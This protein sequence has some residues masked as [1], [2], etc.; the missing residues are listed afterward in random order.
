MQRSHHA[1]DRVV[2]QLQQ[3]EHSVSRRLE[4]EVRVHQRGVVRV[5]AGERRAVVHREAEESLGWGPDFVLCGDAGGQD[6]E[7]VES[8]VVAGELHAK[9]A[10]DY[11]YLDV[12]FRSENFSGESRTVSPLDLREHAGQYVLHMPAVPLVDQFHWE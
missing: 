9:A 6:G 10:D 2:H 12:I 8:V 7:Q 11:Q 4:P 3:R 5:V 1:T